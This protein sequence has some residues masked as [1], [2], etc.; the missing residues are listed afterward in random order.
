[1]KTSFPENNDFSLDLCAELPLV[2]CSDIPVSHGFSTRLGG[3]S[4]GNGLDTLDL[5]MGEESD[6]KENRRRFASALGAKE[7][8][9]FSAKQIHSDMVM[10][11]TENDLGKCFECDAFVTAEKG[12]LLTV[13]VADCVPILMCD[14]ESGVI[15]ASHA[16]WRGT[17]AG[18]APNTV[19]AMCALG[20][21]P[22]N[23]VAAVGQSIKNAVTRW[24][25]PSFRR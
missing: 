10:T 3:V 14:V 8:R 5:G 20:A 1:M 16:G 9:L 11:V 17:V 15:G 18:I 12:L 2:R 22:E 7:D 21:K 25:S 19:K 23:I 4:H 13:K 6:V 24:M